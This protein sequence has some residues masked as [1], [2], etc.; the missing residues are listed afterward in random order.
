MATITRAVG[1]GSGSGS[2]GVG[3]TVVPSPTG[4]DDTALIHT[5]RTAAGIN[6]ILRFSPGTY[7]AGLL[8]SIA[9]QRWELHPQTVIKAPDSATASVL[10]IRA[11]DVSIIGGTIDGNR[12]TVTNQN[13]VGIV[14][15]SQVSGT[16]ISGVRVQNCAGYGIWLVDNVAYRIEDCTVT[17]AALTGIITHTQSRS[18]VDGAIRNNLVDQSSENPATITSHGMTARGG[19]GFTQSRTVIHGNHVVM[20]QNPS[21]TQNRPICLE[22]QLLDSTI[23]SNTTRYGA[24][25]ISLSGCSRV[26][27]TGNTIFGPD[28]AATQQYGIEVAISPRCAIVGNIVEGLDTLTDGIG[29][30]QSGSTDCTVSGNVV[31]QSTGSAIN[32]SG[33]CPRTVI[34]G[35][36]LTITTGRGIT[37]TNG[38]GDATISGNL[39][40]GASSGGAT[41]GIRVWSLTS[42][43]VGALI[44]GNRIRGFPKGVA[45]VGAAALVTDQVM[46]VGNDLTGCTTA[47]SETYTGGASLGTNNKIK[48][49]LNLA[50][51]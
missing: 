49:N 9:G 8:A 46:V 47:W 32:I 13:V 33:G 44:S 5:A 12:P 36:S 37:L 38:S 11:D 40:D 34:T 30:S 20:P 14:S 1:T 3:V 31:R 50:D 39:I 23:S 22:A 51:N 21:D 48:S 18:I 28:S 43:T 17:G 24:M 42:A 45:I 29:F 2:A 15:L 4:G 10:D 6:G 7:R 35:N 27:V 26:V 41:E 16:R 25:G 19:S